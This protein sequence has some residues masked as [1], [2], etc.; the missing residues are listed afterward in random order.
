[1]ASWPG[2]REGPCRARAADP[3]TPGTGGSGEPWSRRQVEEG[4]GWGTSPLN[5]LVVDVGDV[6]HEEYVVSKIVLRITAV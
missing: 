4:A 2:G 1:M 5:D 6:H 3:G